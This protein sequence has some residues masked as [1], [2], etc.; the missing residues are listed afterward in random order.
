M[1]L[2]LQACVF[3][4]KRECVKNEDLT[5]LSCFLLYSLQLP[6]KRGKY[7]TNYL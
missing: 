6:Q 5:P 2:V 3:Q 4:K 7:A 1:S